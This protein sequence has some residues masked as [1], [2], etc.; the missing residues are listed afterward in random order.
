S[1]ISTA[2]PI[3]LAGI[4]LFG[5]AVMVVVEAISSIFTEGIL[6]RRPIRKLLFNVPLLAVTVGAAGL[7]Y[8]M[9]GDFADLGSPMFLIPLLA[10]GI[11]YYLV[12]TW[13]LS[14][15]I[16]FDSGR[17]PYHVWMQNYMWYFFHIFA[18]LPM[19][20]IIALLYSKAGGWTIAL[21]IIPLFLARY[22]FQLYLDM[23]EKNIETVAALTS[24]IDA[25]DAFTHGH[26]YRVSQYATKVAKAIGMSSKEIETL[27]YASLLHDVG[28]I[29]VSNTVL[30]KVEPLTDEEWISLKAHPD[31]GADIVERLKFLKEA[32]EIIRCHHERPDGTGYPRGLKNDKIPLGA[33]ILNVV[34]AFDAMTSNRPYRDAL[35]PEVVI[36]E[37]RK[38]RGSQFHAE[39]ADLVLELY[40]GG[41]FDGIIGSNATPGIYDSLKETIQV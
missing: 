27:E 3:D 2:S 4:V 8:R 29:A 31:V 10:A 5:P 6:Q 19:G 16:A 14:L 40:R 1:T 21:F 37:L 13:S 24:A 23:R 22:S 36:N 12:N 17:N 35:S 32:A 39:V 9:F 33:H 28:K 26:S 34:D 11:V 20:A 15:I 38:Y 30:Q 7:T 41:E 18:F 25:S